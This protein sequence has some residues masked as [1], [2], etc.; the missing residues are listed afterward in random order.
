MMPLSKEELQKVLD[1]PEDSVEFLK[2]VERVDSSPEIRSELLKSSQDTST[3]WM[4][5]TFALRK[6]ELPKREELAA[7][8]SALSFSR[9]ISLNNLETLKPT[10]EQ[11]PLLNSDD[12]R[13]LL[14]PATHPELL[15]RIG[16]YDIERIV[17]QGGM[18]VVFKAYDSELHRI[19]AVKAMAPHLA[20]NSTARKRFAKEARSIAAIVHPHVIPILDV[21][22]DGPSPYIVMQF[23]NGQSLQE[24]VESNGP[25]SVAEA[26]R[27]ADQIASA[28]SA[29]HERGLVHRDVKPANVLLEESVERVLLSDFGLARTM[30][31]AAL[32]RTGSVV[33]TPFYMSPEQ[34]EAGTADPRSDMFSLGSVLYFMLTGLPPFRAQ[35][36]ISVIVHICQTPHL[37]LE[38]VNSDT[39]IE[40]ARLVD[41]LLEKDPKERVQTADELRQEIL[42]LL[43]AMQQGRL[44]LLKPLGRGDALKKSIRYRIAIVGA[45]LVSASVLSLWGLWPE[46]WTKGQPNAGSSSSPQIEKPLESTIEDDTNQWNASVYGVQAQAS[47]LLRVWQHDNAI[48]NE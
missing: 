30:D 6:G 29:A 34:A 3:L 40:V 45:L 10:Q 48:L 19:V 36:S 28:L 21:Q 5:V 11:E 46:S 39:P 2:L 43:S 42:G 38:Q 8:E 47:E 17:G 20:S 31:D 12:I 14:E 25:L 33:G 41:R 16:R 32:T 9:A 4:D 27:I 35:T 26:L 44:S 18:G 22:I 1:A 23:V 37:P 13:N 15:G 24:R 7:T